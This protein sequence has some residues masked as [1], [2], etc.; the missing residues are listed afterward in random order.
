MQ[1]ITLPTFSLL[2]LSHFS[3]DVV[4]NSDYAG[5]CNTIELSGPDSHE[6][7]WAIVANCE[8]ESGIYNLDTEININVCFTNNGGNLAAELK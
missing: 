8:T 4:A 1:F 6:S 3:L 7:R 2:I 5:R